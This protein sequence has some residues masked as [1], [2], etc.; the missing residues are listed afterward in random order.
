MHV[1]TNKNFPPPP[2]KLV[3]NEDERN[4][5]SYRKGK[6]SALRVFSE[7]EREKKRLAKQAQTHEQIQQNYSEKK[8]HSLYIIPDEYGV[9]AVIYCKQR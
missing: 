8:N 3:E 4:N 7:R 2:Q 5:S 6:T 1:F 9:R